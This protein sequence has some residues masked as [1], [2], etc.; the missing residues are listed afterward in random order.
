MEENDQRSNRS[1]GDVNIER[2]RDFAHIFGGVMTES[3]YARAVRRWSPL[4]EMPMEEL[5]R[6]MV[7]IKSLLPLCDIA[8]LIEERPELYLG[9]PEQEVQVGTRLGSWLGWVIPSR[10]VQVGQGVYVTGTG[11]QFCLRL[12]S[13]QGLGLDPEPL[14][15]I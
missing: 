12:V 3:S 8:F 14:G 11:S 4:N 2:F 9:A 1:N 6:R 5:A 7:I 15:Q 13:S 10:D